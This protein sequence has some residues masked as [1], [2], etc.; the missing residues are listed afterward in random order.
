[1]LLIREEL[2]RGFP[3]GES[4]I[5]LGVFDGVHR[6]HG[7]LVDR[8]RREAG[9]RGLSPGVVTFHPSPISVLRPDIPLA[10]LE[11][12][13]RRVEL[14]G[15]LGAEF[16]T[17]VS[18]TSELA[19]VSAGEFVRLLAEEARVRLVVVG[20]D[21]ALGRGREGTAERLAEL[22]APLGIEVLTVGLVDDDGSKVSSTRIRQALA[23]GE[24]EEVARLLGRPYS[25]RGPVL[26]GDERGRRIGF[27]TLNIG[28]GPDRALPPNGVYVCRAAVGGAHHDAVTNIG[29]RPTFDGTS[30]QVETHLLD[31][32]GD[33][34]GEHASI[35]LLH[36]LREER[37]FPG[38]DGLV[39]QITQDVAESRR[40][41]SS[42]VPA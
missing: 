11:S 19:Q 35:D 9:S 16:V 33:L 14:L 2:R 41:L 31:F 17:V 37:R 7:A 34:Y 21:F 29:V 6:G 18:F 20:G 40:Y 38:P 27:P 13:E 3:P 10:Y 26:R 8:L 23:A 1:M 36:R 4:A 5:T 12:L 25:L 32:S 42:R 39:A 22:A 24:M 30:R 15:E 28:V